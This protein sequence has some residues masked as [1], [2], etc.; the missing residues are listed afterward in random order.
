MPERVAGRTVWTRDR[1]EV[2]A[3]ATSPPALA[4]DAP[5]VRVS[6]PG[7]APG[8]LAETVAPVTLIGSR[9]DCQ[10]PIPH[11]DVS[12]IHCALCNDG[13]HVLVCD[14]RS[15]MGT[16]VNGRRVVVARL[17]PGD[18]LHVGSVPLRLEFLRLP[19]HQGIDPDP[20]L[21]SPPLKLIVG[22]SSVEIARQPAVIGR[23]NSCDVVIDTPDVSLAHALI[24]CL[25]GR[26]LICDLSSRSGTLLDGERISLAWLRDGD[27]LTIGGESI[28]VRWL[29]PDSGGRQAASAGP[30]ATAVADLPVERAR[31]DHDFQGGPAA[32]PPGAAPVPPA[33][34]NSPRE[35]ELAALAALSAAEAAAGSGD[36]SGLE[37][38]IALLQGQLLAFRLR[39]E[40]RS[41]EIE[42]RALE[43]EAH[44]A[45]L[46]KEGAALEQ[47]RAELETIREQTAQSS[48]SLRKCRRKLA[49]RLRAYRGL[50]RELADQRAGLEAARA[51]LG[52]GRELLTAQLAELTRDRAALEQA[53]SGLA[54]DR[55]ALE[56]VLSEV[57][58]REAACA[59]RE[60]ELKTLAAALETRQRELQAR[61][62]ELRERQAASHEA[63]RKLAQLRHLIEST[64]RAF[65]EMQAG[66]A[67]V[68]PHASRG[69]APAGG[70]SGRLLGSAGA[71]GTGEADG[72]AQPKSGTDSGRADASGSLGKESLPAPLVGEP[73]FAGP[74][75]LPQEQWPP[76]LRE[77]LQVLRRVSKKSE[78]ELIQQVWSEHEKRIG[79]QQAPSAG[80]SRR[81]RSRS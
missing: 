78:E 29:S 65:A 47:R 76:E 48:E 69:V 57:S 17:K 26:P 12:Q 21:L 2:A 23:R 13:R 51:E 18:E 38:S 6:A 79:G 81:T 67:K 11:A 53:K 22:P 16:F 3:V 52:E 9:R 62:N 43:L 59:A 36:L 74:R 68:A 10:L 46:A 33:T 75:V 5:H 31:L 4:G 49:A 42:R 61:E 64:A 77:R 58:A 56:Q 27:R 15:R 32:A 71:V 60:T 80:S 7:H 54:R 37:Q 73:I 39:L 44:S 34:A 24:F 19:L 30:A 35:A 40:Q 8:A 20:T 63:D 25:N 14:L 55:S 66:E 41:S 1:V 72:G 45:R 70:R 28:E 50:R